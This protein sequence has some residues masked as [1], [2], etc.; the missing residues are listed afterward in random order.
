MKII[1]NRIKPK[2]IFDINMNIEIFQRDGIEIK[3]D[4][5]QINN[6]INHENISLTINK[7]NFEI[8]KIEKDFLDDL[9]KM[10]E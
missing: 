1:D 10:L 2:K 5:Y 7:R 4:I 3:K 6:K 8:T 9:I